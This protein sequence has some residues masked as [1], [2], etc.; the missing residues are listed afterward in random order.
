MVDNHEERNLCSRE[1]GGGPEVTLLTPL[2]ITKKKG[3]EEH[4]NSTGFAI[5]DDNNDVDTAMMGGDSG[6]GDEEDQ[7]REKREEH[8]D[9]S[10]TGFAI[11]NDNDDVDV[12]VDTVIQ[13]KVRRLLQTTMKDLYR[14]GRLPI[15]LAVTIIWLCYETR[16][17][18]NPRAGS[19][20][21]ATKNVYKKD[22]EKGTMM[23][24]VSSSN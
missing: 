4:G 18:W 23:G 20:Y 24:S 17:W 9:N 16:V 22:T 1:G 8:N 6:G 2:L 19:S 15:C 7:L 13:T 5:D 12:D 3:G 10:C 11:D 14:S 21:L